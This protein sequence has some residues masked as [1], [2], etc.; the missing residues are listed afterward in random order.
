M[1]RGKKHFL[2]R[3]RTP[4]GVRGLK[5]EAGSEQQVTSESHPTRGAWIEMFIC[6]QIYQKYEILEKNALLRLSQS[7]Y[8]AYL[9]GST[10]EYHGNGNTHQNKNRCDNDK[11]QQ[12][13]MI[14]IEPE[15]VFQ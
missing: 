2:G 8:N 3:C 13:K 4:H 9:T 5:S 12:R 14:G 11:W 10:V 7:F 15:H 6:R 1:F